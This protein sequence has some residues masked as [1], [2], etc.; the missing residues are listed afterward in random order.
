[1]GKVGCDEVSANGS[2]WVPKT[3]EFQSGHGVVPWYK[4][5]YTLNI[6][7]A[8]WLMQKKTHPN[9]KIRYDEK[10]VKL[11][12]Q[13]LKWSLHWLNFKGIGRK[14]KEVNFLTP[15]NFRY[16]THFE[17]LSSH[18]EPLYLGNGGSGPSTIYIV[19][20]LSKDSWVKISGWN[21]SATQCI[22]TK[23]TFSSTFVH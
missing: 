18:F 1:M 5:C 19:G 2:I 7:A 15:L 20:I 21:F 17:P 10:L 8:I 4:M 12:Q 3:S 16:R 9:P 11:N 14:L 23:N 13:G 22:S 6:M